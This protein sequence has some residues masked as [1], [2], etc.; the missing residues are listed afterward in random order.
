MTRRLLRIVTLLLL[1]SFQVGSLSANAVA[2]DS[3][4][5]QVH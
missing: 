1:G 2:A 5:T 4:F 3:G